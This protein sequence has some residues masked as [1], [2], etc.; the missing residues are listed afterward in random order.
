MS[1]PHPIWACRLSRPTS[2]HTNLADL[3]S[4]TDYAI[5]AVATIEARNICALIEF[6]L[7][8]NGTITVEVDILGL[9]G[10]QSVFCYALSNVQPEVTTLK[11][12]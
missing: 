8:D 9:K 4:V 5:G 12:L 11:Q 2:L 6:D 3:F 7:E 1:V 10:F